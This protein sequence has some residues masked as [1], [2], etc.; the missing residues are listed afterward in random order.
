MEIRI[1]RNENSSQTNVYSHYS[2]YYSGLIAN[3]GALGLLEIDDFYFADW[4]TK[5]DVSISWINMA[6]IRA[7]VNVVGLNPTEAKSNIFLYLLSV[8]NF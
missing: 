1:F 2:N 3:E 6:V 7:K 8:P 5:S 4:A